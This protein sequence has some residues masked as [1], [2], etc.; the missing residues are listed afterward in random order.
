[1]T[2]LCFSV[3]TIAKKNVFTRKGHFVTRPPP[4]KKYEEST[5]AVS[6]Y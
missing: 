1:M 5:R 2:E 6:G 3:E 4:K